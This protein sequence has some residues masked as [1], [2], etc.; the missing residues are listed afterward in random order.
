MSEYIELVNSWVLFSA[1][2]SHRWRERPQ[3][4]LGSSRAE[5]GE[6]RLAPVPLHQRSRGERGRDAGDCGRVACVKEKTDEI[7]ALRDI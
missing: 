4:A 6:L 7:E 3:V 2:Y 1:L 5:Y